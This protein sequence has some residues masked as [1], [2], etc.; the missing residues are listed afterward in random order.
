[1]DTST[2][3]LVLSNG[4]MTLAGDALTLQFNESQQLSGTQNRDCYIPLSA[5]V[6]RQ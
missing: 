4:V 3:R 2:A 5:A 6:T 1:V